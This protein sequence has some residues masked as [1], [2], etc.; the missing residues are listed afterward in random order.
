MDIQILCAFLL[1][2]QSSNQFVHVIGP[3]MTKMM[4]E[5]YEEKIK[6]DGMENPTDYEKL[7][8][9]EQLQHFFKYVDTCQDFFDNKFLVFIYNLMINRNFI[10]T[11]L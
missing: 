6:L 3:T 7:H 10:V 1:H 2:N 11:R 8:Y 4:Q 9:H 5:V